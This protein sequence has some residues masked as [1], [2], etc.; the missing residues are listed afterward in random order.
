MINNTIKPAELNEVK[1]WELFL[2]LNIKTISIIRIAKP[3]T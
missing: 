2:L 3:M 1:S